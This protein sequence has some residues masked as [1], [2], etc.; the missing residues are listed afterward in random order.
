MQKPKRVYLNPNKTPKCKQNIKQKKNNADRRTKFQ[1]NPIT[2]YDF[3]KQ[4]P[5]KINQQNTNE[6]NQYVIL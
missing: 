2:I 4:T 3:I 5:F 6:T 1:A